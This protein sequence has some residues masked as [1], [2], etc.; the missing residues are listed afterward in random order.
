V[1]FDPDEEV[2]QVVEL[3]F[4]K[5]EELGTLHALI[6]YLVA[7]DIRIGVRVREE[8]G[9]G[10]LE[11]RAPKWTTLQNMLKNP[12][13]AGAYA[14]GRRRTDPRKRK[15]GRRSTGR[16]SPSSGGWHVLLKARLPAYI[17]WQTYEK[18]PRAVT[19]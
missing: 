16:T 5:F 2:Q 18:K 10:E 6:R 4:R 9:K 11:W 3:I 13:Y 15:P 7:H 1:V 12:I 17:S 19:G 8:E 14:Y